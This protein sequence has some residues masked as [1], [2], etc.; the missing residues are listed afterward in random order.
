[1]EPL[2]EFEVTLHF[3]GDG[4]LGGVHEYAPY[5]ESHATFGQYKTRSR[6]PLQVTGREKRP[7]TGHRRVHH[8][9]GPPTTA[10]KAPRTISDIACGVLDASSAKARI[11]AVRR[12]LCVPSA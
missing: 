8:G 1:M 5:I 6:M 3:R 7:G 9:G 2:S 11:A 12:S 10:P 4:L